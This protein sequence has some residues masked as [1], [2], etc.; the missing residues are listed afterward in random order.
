MNR[1]EQNGLRSKVSIFNYKDYREY[2]RD[3]Y[4]HSK[5]RNRS[6]SYNLFSKKAGF[7]SINFFMLVMQG[8]RNLTEESLRKVIVG[9]GLNKQEQ[10]FFRNLVFFNQ[11]REHND[12]NFYYHKLLQ[13]RKYQKIRPLEGSQYEFYSKWY[14]PVVRELVIAKDFDGTPEWIAGHISPKITVAQA[15]RSIELLENLGLIKKVEP[16]KWKQT[17]PLIT[18]NPNVVSLAAH[19]FHKELIGLSMAVMDTLTTKERD[20]SS[21][22]L[23]VKRERLAQIREKIREFRKELLEMVSEDDVPDEVAQINIQFFPVSKCKR[24]DD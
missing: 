7:R 23:G 14:N 19:N 22:T 16:N 17:D 8:K 10:E 18:A 1:E 21:L 15:K 6:F 12:K 4:G 3:W 2:L 24:E 9:L 20:T 11:S 13:S 5:K